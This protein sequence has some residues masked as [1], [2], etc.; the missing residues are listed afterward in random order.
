MMPVAITIR[1]AIT[2]ALCLCLAAG[3]AAHDDRH[4]APPAQG[5]A[6]GS[7]SFA[8]AEPL[9]IPDLPVTDADGRSGGLRSRLPQSAPVILSFTYTGCTSLCDVTNA[10][11]L[12]VEDALDEVGDADTRIV[13]LT[14]DPAT[15][16][17]ERLSEARRE[18]GS[19]PR[20]LWMT[21]GISGTGAILDRLGVSIGAIETHDPM[22]LVGRTCLGRFVR[23]VGLPDP[24]A[25]ARLAA[26]LPPCEG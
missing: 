4:H 3:A 8:G 20:W 25:L 15:D 11:L 26:D 19:G 13:T 10:I 21:G 5:A 7:T 23:V 16:T 12:G 24:V 18:L 1:P 22:F 9:V 17:P 6:A 14:I 2:V